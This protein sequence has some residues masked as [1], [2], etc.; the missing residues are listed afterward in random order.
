MEAAR[1]VDEA[2][3]SLDLANEPSPCDIDLEAEIAAS[4]SEVA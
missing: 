3:G 2:A 4:F 1:L